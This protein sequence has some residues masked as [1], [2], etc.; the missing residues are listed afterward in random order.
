MIIQFHTPKGIVKVNT[1]TVT[2]EKLATLGITREVLNNQIPRDLFAEIDNL[3]A[4]IKKLE[5]KE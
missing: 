5:E 1:D 4:R 2:N 3:E